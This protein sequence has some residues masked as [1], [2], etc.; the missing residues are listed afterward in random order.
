MGPGLRSHLSNGGTTCLPGSLGSGWS[1]EEK[2]NG[3]GSKKRQSRAEETQAAEAESLGS[4]VARRGC[5]GQN[6][7]IAT[8]QDQVVVA[9]GMESLLSA[10]ATAHGRTNTRDEELYGLVI[11]REHAATLSVLPTRSASPA[12]VPPAAC[13]WAAGPR[14]WLRQCRGRG[15]SVG[16]GGS[17]SCG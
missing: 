14:E 12:S 1:P 16:A 13:P 8:G 7:R 9:V 4:V 15:G 2:L 6:C 3:Q 17:R 11:S 10:S 5:A